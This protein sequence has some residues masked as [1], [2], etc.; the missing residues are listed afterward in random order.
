MSSPLL[1]PLFSSPLLSSPLLATRSS[2]LFL[3]RASLFPFLYPCPPQC[4][5]FPYTSWDNYQNCFI[6]AIITGD[7]PCPPW[8][9]PPPS[10]PPSAPLF[11]YCPL[12]NATDTR[13]SISFHTPSAPCL[14]IV[15]VSLRVSP[16]FRLSPRT[17]LSFAWT[18]NTVSW[19]FEPFSSRFRENRPRSSRRHCNYRAS[20]CCNHAITSRAGAR[21]SCEFI[22]FSMNISERIPSTSPSVPRGFTCAPSRIEIDQ[23]LTGAV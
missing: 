22:S 17:L 13:S 6:V 20:Q 19:R 2:S 18:Y 23:K 4:R 5:V 9:R 11:C 15:Y 14:R 1:S 7:M 16:G 3:C 21:L 12:R 8:L 10:P